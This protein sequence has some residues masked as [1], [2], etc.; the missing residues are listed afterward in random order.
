MKDEKITPSDNNSVSKPGSDPENKFKENQEHHLDH[1][2]LN[3][4]AGSA[5]DRTKAR[6]GDG[7]ANEGTIE[8]FEEER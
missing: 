4:I 1:N 2:T 6:T 7:L 8:N 5:V 3:N